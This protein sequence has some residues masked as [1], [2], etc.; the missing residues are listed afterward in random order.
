MHAKDWD[1]L[2]HLEPFGCLPET[3]AR[4][5]MPSTKEQL[6]VL[7]IIYDEHTGKA[8]VINRLEAFVDMIYRRKKNRGKV[9]RIGSPLTVDSCEGEIMEAYLG[10]DV[11]SVTTKFAVL[12]K[13]DELVTSLYLLTQGKPIEMVQQGLKQIKSQL[14]EDI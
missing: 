8:G 4:N 3:M 12:D 13:N 7:N 5:I 6:P 14:P 9:V 10:I 1:G 11:G 2:V